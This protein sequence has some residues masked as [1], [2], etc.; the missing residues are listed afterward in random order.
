[1]SKI[2]KAAKEK[3]TFVKESKRLR[4]DETVTNYMGGQSYTVDPI[5]RLKMVTASSIFGEPQYYRQTGFNNKKNVRNGVEFAK[6]SG[7]CLF[8]ERYKEEIDTATYMEQVI[9]SALDYDFKAT[10]E[11]AVTLRKE[12]YMR[13][14]PQV[15][16]VRAAI[17]P[18]RA[19][20]CKDD[21]TA[22]FRKTNVQVMQRADDV[23]EQM[24]YYIYINNGTVKNCPSV[25][26]RSWKEKI[27]SLDA[28]QMNKY[29]GND[30][31]NV[32]RVCHAS[33]N[34]V[35]EL[36]KTGKVHVEENKKTWENL[37]SD[38]KLW[39]EI[40]QTIRLPHMA[41]LRNM[42]G[43]FSEINNL[44]I[45]KQYTENLKSGVLKGK[46]LPFRYYSAYNTLNRANETIVN[47]KMHLLDSL[48]ECMDISLDNMPKLKGRTMCLSD[49]SGSA[50]GNFNSEYGTVTVAE[51]DN[52]SSVITSMNSDE[53]YVGKF[54]NELKVYEISKRNGC[55]KQANEIS[56]SRYKDVGSATEGGI[57][58]F[59]KNAIENKEHW[60]NIFI[61]SDMQAGTG[62]LY[63]TEKHQKEYRK[64]YGTGHS[65]NFV[66]VF[67]LVE[68]YRKRVNPKV[69]VFS[70][71]TAGY[72][73][74]VV[75]N[76]AYRTT[77]LYGWTGK[78]AVF[79]AKMNELW[80]EVDKR[81]EATQ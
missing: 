55:L 71:Q 11:W 37:H 42:R 64:Q 28:Y 20:I 50:W 76:F 27:E 81:C 60:D 59:F 56:S 5:M 75:P 43:V 73:N 34:H 38:G 47:H 63:G 26:K 77:L 70:V 67:A 31:I 48:E 18:K 79:A 12:Y 4:L 13:L 62:G 3:T 41:A 22:W 61:Y 58:L 8:G 44:D 65:N 78:E 33:K 53:G 10:V 23:I 40:L 51:I 80:D 54:G 1:M 68:E 35:P 29:G 69:N 74:S 14:N 6:I 2:T 49:N 21:K 46:Q 16:M 24:N 45:A 66:N 9:D 39:E 32:C 19:E 25:L 15:I 36:M 72:D 7:I 17:H 52:L 30:M 57:W